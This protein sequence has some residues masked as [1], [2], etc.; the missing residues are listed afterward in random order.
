MDEQKAYYSYLMHRSKFSFFVRKFF[1]RDFVY[2]FHGKVLDIGCGIG[3]FLEEYPNSVGMDIN[4]YLVQHCKNR[5]MVTNVASIL[6]LPYSSSSFDGVLIS[7]VIEH[8]HDADQAVEEAV[9]ILKTGG[10]LGISCPF[11][12]GFRHD[13][14]HVRMFKADDL[15]ELGSKYNMEVER[16]YSFP[17]GGLFLGKSLYFFELRAIYKKL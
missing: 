14:T 8:L 13:P 3:E 9:R 17:P 15:R 1:V 10:I 12:A 11:E 6:N 4:P 7:N 5:G 2:W 16:I